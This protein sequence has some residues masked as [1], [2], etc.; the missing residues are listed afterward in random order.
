MNNILQERAK[1]LFNNPIAPDELNEYN[2]KA[3][4]KAIEWLGQRWTLHNSNAVAKK[5]A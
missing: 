3:W 2:Q 5:D 1:H 4:L